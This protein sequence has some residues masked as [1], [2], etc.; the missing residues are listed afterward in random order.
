MVQG[1]QGQNTSQDQN[2]GLL[3]I[4]K[5]RPSSTKNKLTRRVLPEAAQSVNGFR[6]LQFLMQLFSKKLR[7]EGFEPSEALATGS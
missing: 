3:R 1:A 5:T 2:D 4:K 7:G 6:R